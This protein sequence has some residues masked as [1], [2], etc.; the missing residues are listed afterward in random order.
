M[1]AAPGSPEFPY[2]RRA[3]GPSGVVE[4]ATAAVAPS[5][6]STQPDRDSMPSAAPVLLQRSQIAVVSKEKD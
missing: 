6:I 3:P 2:R 1:R 5:R 4:Y